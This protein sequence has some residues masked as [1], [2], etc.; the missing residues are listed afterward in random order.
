MWVALAAA[1]ALAT[2]SCGSPLAR[3]D[4]GSA[5]EKAEGTFLDLDDAGFR[6]RFNELSGL[7]LPCMAD[8]VPPDLA[9]RTHRLMAIHLFGLGDREGA[10]R[11]ISAARAVAGETALPG[12][13]LAGHELAAAWSAASRA[14]QARRVPEPRAGSVAFDGV[15]HRDRPIDLPTVAQVFDGAGRAMETV[16]LG[17]GDPLPEYAAVPRRR[18]A[19][20]AI[21][22]SSAA[23]GVG[24]WVGAGVTHGEVYRL[25]ED[26]GATAAQLDRLRGTTN[27]LS[28]LGGVGVVAAV[29]AG[30]GA[31]LVGSR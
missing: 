20:I 7:V 19:L 28:V 16:Y 12:D 29:G 24:A 13:L 3:D 27:L 9:A 5:I 14:P 4:L 10:V 26:P 11:A 8:L 31:V 17:P 2:D 23:A 30:T 21:A 18:N 15:N 6:D 1:A 22:A 25:V